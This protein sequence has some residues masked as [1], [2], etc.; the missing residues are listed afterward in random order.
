MRRGSSIG[1]PIVGRLSAPKPRLSGRAFVPCSRRCAVEIGETGRTACSKS[2]RQAARRRRRGWPLAHR[3]CILGRVWNVIAR[4]GVYA[5]VYAPEVLTQRLL[6]ERGI[7]EAARSRIRD[8]E[9]AF[10]PGEGGPKGEITIG[11][12]LKHLQKASNPSP[13]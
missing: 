13:L 2:V 8:D 10:R 1:E 11:L 12:T 5:G 6:D 9:A 4:G 7:A 3:T